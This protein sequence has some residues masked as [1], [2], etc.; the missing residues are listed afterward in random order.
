MH[1]KLRDRVGA[2]VHLW[3]GWLLVCLLLCPWADAGAKPSFL[4]PKI[5]MH[6][7]M[8]LEAMADKK[9]DAAL[10]AGL[11]FAAVEAGEL[12]GI[13]IADQGVPALRAVAMGTTW[14]ELHPDGVDG[15]V[16]P[17]HPT[18]GGKPIL[19]LRK[20]AASVPSRRID[21]IRQAFAGFTMLHMKTV[22]SCGAGTTQAA[23]VGGRKMCLKPGTPKQVG[24]TPPVSAFTGLLAPWGKEYVPKASQPPSPADE[25]RC[26]RLSKKG[27]TA[28]VKAFKSAPTAASSSAHSL[29]PGAIFAFEPA[30]VVDPSG[31]KKPKKLD[32]A[33]LLHIMKPQLKHSPP[34]RI[35]N[36][37]KALPQLNIAFD[38]F[39]LD[40]ARSR[41]HFLAH[42]GGEL[43]GTPGDFDI[44]ETFSSLK[45]N[46]IFLGRGPLQVTCRKNYVLA[47]A[48]MD[49]VLEQRIFAAV[50]GLLD[51]PA[52]AIKAWADV[53]LHPRTVQLRNAHNAIKADVKTARDFDKGV[54]LSAAYWHGA[55]CN[56]DMRDL[57]KV[58][59][60][61]TQH[62][63]GSGPGA[64]C[65]SGG[66]TTCS[67]RRQ[68]SI[69]ACIFN[70]ALKT[71]ESG[72]PVDAK[73]PL[74]ICDPTCCIAGCPDTNGVCAKEAEARRKKRRRRKRRR[75]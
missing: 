32:L 57:A 9:G 61:G 46:R 30:S 17:P 55:G 14:W 65:V 68:A 6:A 62:F 5:D 50:V 11:I 22:G 71:L 43:G 74:P 59:N 13:Y 66:N 37:K 38:L 60:V 70:R 33:T 45:C 35:A 15:V 56:R 72:T 20:A 24:T 23:L 18:K 63:L 25:P 47:L 73:C 64:R 53:W 69:K 3:C 31:G 48:Y 51:N 10:E 12:D 40:T 19:V 4:H 16:L 58:S 21:G 1:R 2:S 52:A 49:I 29:T 54:L 8:A 7:Q 44:L 75:K 27:Y 39:K 28:C 34:K 36:L 67:S 41:A 42:Y 26:A